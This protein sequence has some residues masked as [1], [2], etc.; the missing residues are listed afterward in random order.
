MSSNDEQQQHIL[1]IGGGIAGKAL[2]LFLHKASLH[3]LSIRKFTSTI[4][5][6]YPKTEKI[7]LGG[8]LGLAPNGI[9]VLASLGLDEQV[10]QRGGICRRSTFWT[11]GGT[12]LARWE[13]DSQGQFGEAMYGLMRSTIYDILSEELD[14]RGLRIEFEKRVWKVEERGEKVWVEFTDGTT[15]EGD[16]L[17]GADGIDNFHSPLRPPLLPFI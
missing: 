2:S 1:I 14:S 6:A 4:Y 8:G 10:R 11:E 15:A 9:A 5:E 13:H 7:Y 17:I 12:E 16:L 3:P